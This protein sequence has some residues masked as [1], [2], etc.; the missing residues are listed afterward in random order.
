MIELFTPFELRTVTL[1]NRVVMSPMC[2]Y[3]AVDGKVTD[4][5]MLH[6]PTRALGGVGLIVVEASAVEARGRI[7]AEDL[8][9]WTDDQLPGLRALAGT[10]KANGAVPGIQLAHAGRKAGS[11]RGWAS[12]AVPFSWTAVAPS[13][14]GFGEPYPT[15]QALETF[16]LQ[17]V[18]DAFVGAA[19]RSLEAGFEVI[20]LHMA[21]GY[22]LHSF[23]SPLSNFRNDRYGGTLENRMRFPL[24]VATAVREVIPEH[25]P[26][27]VRVSASDWTEGGWSIEDTVQ[28]AR[29]FK[30]LG[31]DL[32]DCSSGGNVASAKIPVGAGYQVPFAESVRREA[33]LATGAVGMIT[34]PHQA[35]TI[36]Q[37]KQADLIFLAR[38]LLSDPFWTFRAAQQ[39]GLNQPIWSPQ[40][41]RAFTI[42]K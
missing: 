33:G 5:H 41:N 18:L 11:A 20:E 9:V 22:L 12:P 23:L 30:P 40:Y 25:L 19:K 21:H 38:L 26:L 10:I 24:E 17:T 34:E 3:S 13:A 42:K 4:W 15:P 36:L 7:S 28:L 31:V 8:G 2:Q 27:L 16:E 1:K 32:I 37:T 14:L 39:L 35:E 29:A 6:Y